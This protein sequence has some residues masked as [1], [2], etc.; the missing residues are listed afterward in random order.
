MEDK[1]PSSQETQAQMRMK[2]YA[3]H[4]FILKHVQF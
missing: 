4:S 2:K 1:F 3:N